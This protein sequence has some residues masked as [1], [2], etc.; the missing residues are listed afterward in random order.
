MSHPREP[1]ASPLTCCGRATPVMAAWYSVPNSGV[2]KSARMRTRG[3]FPTRTYQTVLPCR[4]TCRCRWGGRGR[5][6]CF[7]Q[8]NFV[9]FFEGRFVVAGRIDA[10]NDP[11]SAHAHFYLGRPLLFC[12]ADCAGN[13]GLG[14]VGGGA[15]HFILKSRPSGACSS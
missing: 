3:P 13:I 9:G 14:D 11:L 8:G 5:G 1:K 6:I 2:P 12:R 15:G 7:S 10:N 4:V